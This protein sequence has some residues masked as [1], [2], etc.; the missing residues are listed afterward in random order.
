MRHF[1]IQSLDRNGQ[2]GDQYI[3]D[4]EADLKICLELI[5]VQISRISC[6]RVDECDEDGND[7]Q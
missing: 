2:W 6:I 5:A 7:L 1:R 4:C 3:V